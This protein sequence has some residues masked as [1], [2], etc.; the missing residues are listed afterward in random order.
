MDDPR[1][2]MTQDQ[3]LDIFYNYL[4]RIGNKCADID[5]N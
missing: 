3:H 1:V 5:F 4:Y 2:K